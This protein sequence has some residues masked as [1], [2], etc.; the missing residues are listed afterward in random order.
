LNFDICWSRGL[1]IVKAI[2]KYKMIDTSCRKLRKLKI[3][4]TYAFHRTQKS[5]IWL[6]SSSMILELVSSTRFGRY[7]QEKVEH[8]SWCGFAN[9]FICTMFF[10]EK[11]YLF[12]LLL[13]TSVGFRVKYCI[14]W[15]NVWIRPDNIQSKNG[16]QCKQNYANEWPCRIQ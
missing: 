7:L 4:A 15:Y 2:R 12:Y 10:L 6:T 16:R 3:T 9:S 8:W 13:R 5:K 14:Q 11:I 1:K